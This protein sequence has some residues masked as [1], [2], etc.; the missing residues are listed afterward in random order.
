MKTNRRNFLRGL[1]AAVALPTF[2][3]LAPALETNGGNGGPPLRS[4]YL[5]VPNG[6]ILDAWRPEGSG[7][8]YE[9]NRTMKPLAGFKPHFQVIS[10]LEHENG[11]AGKDG[12]GDH[13]RANATI[14]TG[15]RPRK[16]AGADIHLGISV[17][18]V[19]A[20]AIGRN[21]RFASLELAT[22][23]VRKSGGCDSGYSC[24]YQ[25]NLSWRSEVTPMAPE[26]N[27]RL[28]FERLFGVGN[29]SERRT[30]HAKR[31][32]QKRS[33]LDFVLED[34]RSLR[35]QL[36]GNDRH[37]LD[38]YLTGVREVELRIERNE[39]FRLPKVAMEAPEGIPRK[40]E[41]HVRLMID[42]L[43]LA[44][45]TDSTRIATFSLAHDGSN[46]SFKDIGVSEGHHFLSHHQEEKEKMEK[47][48][49][50]DEF[51]AR[52]FAYYLEKMDAAKDVD[53]RSLL[54]NSMTLYASG[55]SD[56]NRHRHDDLPVI[57][58]G[59][60]GG[61]LKPGRHLKLSGKTPMSNLYV[62]LLDV[63]GAPV[64]RFG[65]STGPLKD[66]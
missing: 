18:Q 34:A 48:R 63:M 58:A 24:A 55:L 56:G 50:I 52:Q 21:T 10:G 15:A 46:L 38:E 28:V 59:H 65:D 19:A 6:V 49:K 5:Y 3:S 40:Y 29:D 62:R 16:T 51:Y 26:N 53:G 22:D 54:H 27:P 37:K 39:D 13:A 45:Q 8:N 66:V 57:L 23:A 44:F 33:I 4:A 1:G 11:W 60:A 64:E 31:I 7:E 35:G 12:A 9:L 41:D 14:L 25:F 47:L 30:N 61:A 2:E 36:G 42:L 43:V 20:N 32:A 17:D